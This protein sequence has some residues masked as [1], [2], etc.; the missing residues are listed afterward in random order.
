MRIHSMLVNPITWTTRI[1]TCQVLPQKTRTEPASQALAVQMGTQSHCPV[2]GT[3]WHL[4]GAQGEEALWQ[5]DLTG[6]GNIIQWPLHSR[7]PTCRALS[8]DPLHAALPERTMDVSLTS[9]AS[10]TSSTSGCRTR[11][12]FTEFGLNIILFPYSKFIIL[13]FRE[14][15]FTFFQWD[16]DNHCIKRQPHDYLWLGVFFSDTKRTS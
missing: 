16:I 7:G 9:T 4:K 1:S 10:N 8:R 11:A 12:V 14:R 5:Q 2:V 15:C 13:Y 6:L 3:G